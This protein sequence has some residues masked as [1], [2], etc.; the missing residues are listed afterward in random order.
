M[1][2]FSDI[3]FALR[4]LIK[5]PGSSAMAILVMAVGTGVA[6]T[7]FAFVN[8]VLWSSLGLKNDREVLYLEWSEGDKIRDRTEINPL[9]YEVLKRES[10]SF[11]KMTGWRWTTQS[12]QNPSNESYAKMYSTA[13]VEVDFFEMIEQPPLLGRTFEAND[14]IDGFTGNIIISHSVWD[15]QFNGDESAIGSI[16]MFNNKPCEIVGI[17]P[18]G[19]MFPDDIQVWAATDWR[20]ARENDRR[21]W[22]KVWV[23]GILKKGV[24]RAQ[25]ET[26][27]ATIAGRLAQE[28]PETNENLTAIEMQRYVL[29][30]AEVGGSASFVTICYILL[31]C[32]ILVLG[33][34]SANVFNLIMTRIATRTS[35]LSVRNAMG[36]S[37]THIV[38]QVVLDGLIL[39]LLGTLGGTLI[40]GWSLKLLWAKFAQQRFIPYWWHMDMDGRV[41]GFVIAV[42]LLSALASSLIPGLRASRS[43]VAENLKDDS[44]T[45][46]GLFIGALSKIILGF[47]ITVTGVLAFVSVMMLLVWVHLKSREL[48][49]EPETILNAR[50]TMLATHSE[51]EGPAMNQ[52]QTAMR[53]R[54]LTYPG[55]EAAAFTTAAGG[56]A[57]PSQGGGFGAREIEIEG[58]VYG[59]DSP[60]PKVDFIA[61]TDGFEA[62]F[63]VEPLIGRSLSSLDT[64]D[65]ELVCMVNKSFTDTYWPNEDPIGKRINIL[66]V[67]WSKGYRTVVGVT[68][69]IMPKPMPG[70]NLVEKGYI[71]IY[72][73]YTQT[74]G[75]GNQSL[76]MKTKGDPHDYAE[77]L[78]KE[79]RAVAPTQAIEGRMMTLREVLD[80]R[81]VTMDLIFMMFGVFG[82]ASLILGV[83]GLYAIMSF[84]TK[85]RFRE[86]GIRMALGAD[87]KEIMMAVVKRGSLLLAIGGVLG[88]GAGHAATMV[89]KSTIDVHELPLGYTYPIVIAILTLATA[90][91]MG[92]PAWRASRISPNQALRVD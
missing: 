62:V 24:S 10:E 86:F 48:S 51:E 52:Q 7:M 30:Y 26:E 58:D 28:F 42:V 16:A 34:A 29:W 15:E 43:S 80:Q 27:L 56:G 53:E 88:V 60:K 61:V 6:I 73:P 41:M 54:L 69:N 57:L 75:L 70:E 66:G 8:G 23:V 11:D 36:A 90:V 50:L 84:T 78:R 74:Y 64:Y 89:L 45:S 39:T 83:V 2:L 91:S 82:A 21:H 14:V 72:V 13:Y 77:I 38:M 9:D 19:F 33:V 12:F 25:A 20:L 35:E 47:Q 5:N 40:A 4:L 71:K 31:F 37:R 68:P 81:M 76:V 55:V 18:P 67:Q 32:A 79:L 3:H 1:N 46:S 63:G 44:R 49:Y 65:T 59:P 85:Q 87:S 22:M 92:L 17:M